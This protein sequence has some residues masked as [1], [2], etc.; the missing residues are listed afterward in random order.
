MRKILLTTII[1]FVVSFLFSS[2]ALAQAKAKTTI[3][4]PVFMVGENQIVDKPIDGDLMISGGQIKITS[5]IKGDAYIAGGQ[6]DISGTINGNLIVVG[7]NITI[8]GKVLKNIIVGAGQVKIDN[9]ADIGGYVLAGG[10][11]VDLLGRFSGPVKVGAGDLL[12]G[13][14][15]ILNGNLEADVGTTSIS[16]T[17][18]I[19]GEKNIR[20]HETKKVDR[21]ER[22][23]RPFQKVVG[24][25]EIFSFF[26]KLV[27]LLVLVK[28]FGQKIIKTDAKNS[29]WSSIGS[30]LI[31][32]IVT[33]FLMLMLMVTVIALPLSGIVLSL[34]LVSISLSG[35]VTSILA[36]NYISQKGYIK[37]KN[38]YF[39]SFLGL[40]LLTLIGLIPFIGALT[41]FI[42]LLFGL[43]IIFNGL[44][45]Y[46]SKN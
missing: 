15:A 16:S 12:I 1:V 33:P 31:L 34:Y 24:V 21:S 20:I 23:V 45:K 6:V 27:I 9:S 3:K 7:G 28:L 10:G 37:T 8:S 5:N 13:E 22:T 18:K 38:L 30:G 29:F 41:K 25:G 42:V 19:I 26:S 39:Q 17:S 35:I 4:L 44:K 40:L 36:G 11:K 43:G 2:N 46:F 14:A 32:L